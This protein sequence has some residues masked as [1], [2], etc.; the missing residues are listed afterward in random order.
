MIN[1][2]Q[3]LIKAQDEKLVILETRVEDVESDLDKSQKINIGF[4][5][6]LLGFLGR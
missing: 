4:L 2:Q 3:S 1:N 6:V 5:V